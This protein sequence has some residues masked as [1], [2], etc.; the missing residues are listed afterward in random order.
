M[1]IALILGERQ[2]PHFGLSSLD[3]NV[4]W[5]TSTRTRSMGI[6]RGGE[7]NQTEAISLSRK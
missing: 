2:G 1:S 3:R 5:D 7:L 6:G 4:N